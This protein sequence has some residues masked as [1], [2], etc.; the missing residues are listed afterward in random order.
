MI[1]TTS[2]NEHDWTSVKYLSVLYHNRT[3]KQLQIFFLMQKYY[4]LPILGTL[5]IF[6]HFLPKE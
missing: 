6:G 4:Q 5:D 1:T 3:Q 2:Y